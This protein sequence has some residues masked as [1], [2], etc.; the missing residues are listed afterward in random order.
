MKVTVEI[1]GRA[2]GFQGE[3][4][5][6][7]WEGTIITTPYKGNY[8]AFRRAM[9]EADRQVIQRIGKPVKT[10]KDMGLAGVNK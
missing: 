9:K 10:E 8:I 6:D 1:V 5:S 4:T 7:L 3:I 2:D